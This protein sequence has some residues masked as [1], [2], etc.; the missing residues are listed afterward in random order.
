MRTIIHHLIRLIMKKNLSNSLAGLNKTIRDYLK[1]QIK[2]VKLNL[3]QKMTKLSLFLISTIV[4]ILLG[5]I[6]FLFAAAAFVIWY[7]NTYGNYLTGLLIISGTILFLGLIF[8][9]TRR[10]IITSIIIKNL[11]S[12]LFEDEDDEKLINSN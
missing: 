10:N 2:L 3:L 6:F 8:V 11:S 4:F 7:G 1:I 5:A 9:I 12:I